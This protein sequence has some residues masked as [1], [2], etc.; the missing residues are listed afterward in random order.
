[1]TVRRVQLMTSVLT[2]P[3]QQT[4]KDSEQKHR[5]QTR[6]PLP[7]HDGKKGANESHFERVGRMIYVITIIFCH[8]SAPLI[9]L[10]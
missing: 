10:L 2:C 3:D 5:E 9:S 8:I 1:M 4:L 6:V 7:D